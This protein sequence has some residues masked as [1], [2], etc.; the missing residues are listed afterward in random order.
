MISLFRSLVCIVITVTPLAWPD[1]AGAT[2]N[3]KDTRIKPVVQ[4]ASAQARQRALLT[5]RQTVDQALVRSHAVGEAA[6]L[7]EAATIEIDQA[8]ASRLPNVSLSLGLERGKSEA[9]N[10]TR[11]DGVVR[12]GGLLVQGPLYD[13]GLSNGLTNWRKN[14]AQVAQ[15]RQISLREEIALQTVS[16]ILE[17]SRF[18]KQGQVYGQHEKRLHCLQD[19]LKKIVAT[20]SGRRSELVQARKTL[21]E[22]RL[23]FQA[24]KTSKTQV[25]QRLR[26]F[27]GDELPRLEGMTAVLLETPPLPEVLR[28]TENASDLMALQ[29]QSNASAAYVTTVRA[30]RRPRIN[31]SVR[32]GISSGADRNRDWAA[33]INVAV[34]LFSPGSR[35]TVDAAVTRANAA[36]LR[37]L[38]SQDARRARVTEVYDQAKANEQR[39]KDIDEILSNS[40][41]LRRATRLQWKSLGRR[42]LFDV[43]SAE[44]DHYGLRIAYVD[45][46]H[47]RL[48]ANALLRSLGMGVNHW[49]EP[50]Q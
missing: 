2:C 21:Q 7:T 42:T 15:H 43:M 3:E 26:R 46:L 11:Y 37:H 40:D 50:T 33:G 34:P 6:L 45:A 17:R 38:D 9:E 8:R 5:L 16:L 36:K 30:E 12:R 23:A 32:H 19:A 24:S 48:Q 27:V 18:Y 20:D 47:D 14:L 44:R 49:L 10:A 29:A 41:K 35:H 13:G 39:L 1:Q 4:S 31:W 25:E 28:D 22:A